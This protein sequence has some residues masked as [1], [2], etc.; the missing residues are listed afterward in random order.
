MVRLPPA[1]TDHH[2]D[3][4]YRAPTGAAEVS[5]LKACPFCGG[6]PEVTSAISGSR[7][8]VECNNEDCVSMPDVSARTR[9]Y[10]VAA[11]NTRKEER[12]E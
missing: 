10:A 3:K 8:Y 4:Q 12:R 6:Q 11:W 5:E 2:P 1:A 7:W 9:E